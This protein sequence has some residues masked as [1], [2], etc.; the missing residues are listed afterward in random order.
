MLRV[1]GIVDLIQFNYTAR[2]SIVNNIRLIQRAGY[3]L[4]SNNG[5]Y[6]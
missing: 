6:C 3:H 4:P 1:Y 5:H 2:K